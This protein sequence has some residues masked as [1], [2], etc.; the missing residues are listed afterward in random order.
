[1]KIEKKRYVMNLSRVRGVFGVDMRKVSAVVGRAEAMDLGMGSDPVTYANSIPPLPAFKNLITNVTTAQKEVKT[2]AVGA[3]AARDVQLGLL[4]AG[5]ES[6]RLFI[7]GLA[8]ANRSRAV[9]IIQNGGLVVAATPTHTKLLLV[10]RNGPQ[11]GSVAC[12]ANVGMLIGT[13]AKHPYAA[14]FFGWQYTVDEGKS[15]VTAPVTANGKTVLTG[16][17]PLTLV[18]VRVNITLLGVTRDWSDVAT[19]RVR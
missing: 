4:I 17:P 8:D 5:M 16:L 1:M 7:Q 9:D 14:R 12:D 13:G 6:E 2:R 11:Q 15:F 3:A 10:L 19:L 18:G